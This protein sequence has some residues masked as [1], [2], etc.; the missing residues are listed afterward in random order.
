MVP[1]LNTT[2]QG[3]LIGIVTHRTYNLVSTAPLVRPPGYPS[4][5]SPNI[6]YI[7][8][9]HQALSLRDQYKQGTVLALEEPVTESQSCNQ[10]PCGEST[11]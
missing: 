1:R 10:L 2:F 6:V 11:Q 4:F 3:S 9:M 5:L 8:Y 7:Y